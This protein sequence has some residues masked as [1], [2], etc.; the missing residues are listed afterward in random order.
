MA[1]VTAGTLLF[2]LDRADERTM[3]PG[4]GMFPPGEPTGRR[5]Q[6]DRKQGRVVSVTYW[7]TVATLLF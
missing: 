2:R 4:Q 5:Q 3:R 6:V 7:M 1:R